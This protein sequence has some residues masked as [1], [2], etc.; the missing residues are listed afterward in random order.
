MSTIRPVL[1]ACVLLCLV[2]FGAYASDASRQAEAARLLDAMDMQATLD[3]SIEM[4]MDSQ[5]AANPALAPYRA[6]ML[7]FF[8]KYMSYQ[9]LK[10]DL[11]AIYADMFT[12]EELAAIRAFQE[13]PVGKK[14]T[15]LQP[16][17]MQRAG[18]LGQ[19]RVQANLSELTRMIEAET[20]RIKA[21]K[22]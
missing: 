11:A 15:H 9:S 22:P 20:A 18:E 17:L 8:R 1:L 3:A 12:E 5:L 14:A 21:A 6:V 10:A 16:Q 19:Q 2:P 4:T 7:D 13:S